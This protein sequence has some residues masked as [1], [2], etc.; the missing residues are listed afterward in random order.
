MKKRQMIK[1]ANAGQKGPSDEIYSAKMYDRFIYTLVHNK[2]F[3][4]TNTLHIFRFASF[5]LM[6]KLQRKAIREKRKTE[7]GRK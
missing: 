4:I 2:F 3:Q 1:L 7:H 6:Y 5:R